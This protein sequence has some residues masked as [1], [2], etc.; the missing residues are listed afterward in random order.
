MEVRSAEGVLF[1][2]HRRLLFPLG[3]LIVALYVGNLLLPIL[4]PVQDA[5][6][7]AIMGITVGSELAYRTLREWNRQKKLDALD[8][9][10]WFFFGLLFA[11]LSG[12][13]L[14]R[15]VWEQVL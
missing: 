8:V 1:Q 4:N 2:L 6:C 11:L 15:L 14:L 3:A 13:K 10:F 12:V 7:F 9:P 5:F